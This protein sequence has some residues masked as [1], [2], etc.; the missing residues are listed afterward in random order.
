[1]CGASKLRDLSF[2]HIALHWADPLTQTLGD[3]VTTAAPIRPLEYQLSVRPL[4]ITLHRDQL[5][6]E[7]LQ[8]TA[9]ER[10]SRSRAECHKP[11]W[12]GKQHGGP[13]QQTDPVELV[14]G[15]LVPGGPE[16]A[17][18]GAAAAAAAAAAGF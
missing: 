4:K 18:R 3:A 9:A 17:R 15:C 10:R 16:A 11:G 14:P 1:M 2:F 8:R 12:W 13:N 6:K 7:T 5:A